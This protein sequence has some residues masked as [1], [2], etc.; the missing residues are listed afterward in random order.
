MRP[1]RSTQPHRNHPSGAKTRQRPTTTNKCPQQTGR[2]YVSVEIMPSQ[3]TETNIVNKLTSD[4]TR[5]VWKEFKELH[6]WFFCKMKNSLTEKLTKWI[7]VPATQ[8]HTLPCQY[9]RY[10]AVTWLGASNKPSRRNSYT[11]KPTNY[12]WVSAEIQYHSLGC[13]YIL[14]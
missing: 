6:T 12:T 3:T 13:K 5:Q 10:I 7:L 4:D 14:L 11:I 9:C 2:S 8:A 1:F